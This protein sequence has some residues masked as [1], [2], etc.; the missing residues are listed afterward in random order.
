MVNNNNQSKVPPSS[1]RE[2]FGLGGSFRAPIPA[3]VLDPSLAHWQKSHLA[4]GTH[5]LHPNSS[6]PPSTPT[7]PSSSPVESSPRHV[8]EERER[9]AVLPGENISVRVLSCL[10]SYSKR[11]WSIFS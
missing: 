4:A 11:R 3:P 5:P 9:F 8:L 7:G 2:I 6:Q 10:F 1:A